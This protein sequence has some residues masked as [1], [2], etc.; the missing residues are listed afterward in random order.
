[1]KTAAASSIIAVFILLFSFQNCQNSQHPDEVHDQ[2]LNTVGSSSSVEL[3]QKAIESISFIIKDSKIITKAGNTY[4]LVYNK[5][6]QLDLK[7]GIIVETSDS[8][9][10]TANYCLSESL[11]NELI[12]ILKSSK[13]CQTQPNLPEGTICSQAMKLPYAQLFTDKEQ[14][15]LGSATD[16]CGSNSIDLC[17]DQSNLLKGYIENLK[18][19]YQQMGCP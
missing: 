11:K 18:K 5:T 8:D 12:S 6:L 9:N 13:V 14:Y 7:T 10:E 2:A 3:N 15:D 4:E 19:E 17:E 16:G 1:M